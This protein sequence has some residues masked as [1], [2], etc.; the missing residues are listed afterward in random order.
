MII[1]KCNKFVVLSFLAVII[2]GISAF[3]TYSS[4]HCDDPSWLAKQE[5]NQCTTYGTSP[6]NFLTALLTVAIIV[7][8]AVIIM[9]VVKML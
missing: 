5:Y 8:A 3:S 1:T 9:F 4:Y 6:D 7:I 2:P